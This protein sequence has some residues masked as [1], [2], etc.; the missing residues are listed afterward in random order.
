MLT[1][2]FTTA[3]FQ[4][5]V[6]PIDA[7]SISFHLST[8]AS[9]G[10]AA[11]L[12]RYPQGDRRLRLADLVVVTAFAQIATLPFIA[13][14]FGDVP[15]LSILANVVAVPLASFAFTLAVAGSAVLWMSASL[16]QALL[17]PAMW[18]A[19]GVLSVAAIYGQPWGV[20]KIGE[21]QPFAMAMGLIVA[22]LVLL[23]AG[24]EFTMAGRQLRVIRGKIG[25]GG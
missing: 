9:I 24:G 13:A 10:L 16:G 15:M 23:Q 1:L 4:L 12:N 8:A 7:S 20:L 6:R 18:A 21:I 22:F 3:A 5:A 19:D 25:P 17:I 14:T 11:G 2:T